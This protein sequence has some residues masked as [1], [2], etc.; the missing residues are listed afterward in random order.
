MDVQW[1]KT[2]KYLGICFQYSTCWFFQTWGLL[3]KAPK[4]F[5]LNAK[6]EARLVIIMSKQQLSYLKPNFWILHC[7][8]LTLIVIKSLLVG[9]PC[10]QDTWNMTVPY[11]NTL[12]WLEIGCVFLGVLIRYCHLRIWQVYWGISLIHLTLLDRFSS[13]LRWQINDDLAYWGLTLS[14]SPV[15]VLNKTLAE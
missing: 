4:T 9:K 8:V 15:W 6:F 11:S 2:F 14:A 12:T 7:T 1:Q 13:T 5:F 3:V 10:N